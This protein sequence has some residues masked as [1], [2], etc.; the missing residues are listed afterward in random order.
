[1]HVCVVCDGKNG[2]VCVCENMGVYIH[3]YVCNSC[4]VGRR[5]RPTH[6][7]HC[8]GSPTAL[9][10]Q[11]WVCVLT[12]CAHIYVYVYMYLCCVSL[13]TNCMRARACLYIRCFDYLSVHV[14]V[15]I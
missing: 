14:C 1:M 11:R 7:R 2:C 5:W 6:P 13:Y 4:E 8:L 9:P 15:F 3:V 10:P 12:V